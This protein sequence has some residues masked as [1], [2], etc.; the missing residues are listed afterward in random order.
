MKVELKN[1]KVHNDM[2]QETT[3]F[4]ATLYIDGKKVGQARNDG[5][6][7]PNMVHFDDPKLYKQFEDFCKSQP[8]HKS[9]FSDKPL[10]MDSDFY[11]SLLVEQAE[12]N[13]QIKRWCKGNKQTVFR[14]KS[15]KEGEWAI[16]KVPFT[17]ATK[18]KLQQQHGAELVEI[19]NER[20]YPEGY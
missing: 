4:S 18:A 20:F 3:C 2:S 13:Q 8:P 17:P 19:A 15:H 7:G 9:K 6:G 12:Q 16:I 10:S 1:L 5:Q 14:T 11:I